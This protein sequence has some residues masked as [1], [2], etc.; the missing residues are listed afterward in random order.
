LSREKYFSI[1]IP[2]LQLCDLTAPVLHSRLAGKKLSKL[3]SVRHF[4]FI[5]YFIFLST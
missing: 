3:F 5:F 1:L 4:Y 2:P